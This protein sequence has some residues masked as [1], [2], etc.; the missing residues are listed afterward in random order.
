MEMWRN[1]LKYSK[2]YLV[3]VFMNR[4]TSLDPDKFSELE[5]LADSF[6]DKCISELGIT[7]GR[8]KFRE[9]CCVT[10]EAIREFEINL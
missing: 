3:S 10:P 1:T 2:E 8:K 5:A 4:Y 6:Y 9:Y 7:A